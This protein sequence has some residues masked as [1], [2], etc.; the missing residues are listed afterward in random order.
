MLN[1]NLVIYLVLFHCFIIGISNYLV[2]FP[3][4]LLDYD[5]TIATFTF[6]F[7]ILATDL[8]VRLSNDYIARKIIA[9]AFIPAF[10][11]S[12][13]FADLRIAIASVAAYGTSQ[14][15][16]IFI[17][18]KIRT[19]LKDDGL[20]ITKYWYAAPALSTF[21]AQIIDTYLFYGIA[22][23]N[24]TDEFMKDNWIIIAGNDF[25]FKII[26]CYI[27]FL[28][29]YLIILNGLFSFLKRRRV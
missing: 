29:I 22:F 1:K 2:Q 21:I 8:T 7:I 28:P 25:I 26:I 4:S 13:Y 5:L 18:S 19:S 20:K 17:F 23:Y 16:D 24:S 15:L 11:I 3:I 27:A 12:L 14:L 6:P 10:F 9:Y